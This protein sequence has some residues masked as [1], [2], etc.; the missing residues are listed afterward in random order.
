MQT[1][2]K[3]MITFHHEQQIMLPIGAQVLT[4]EMQFDQ[5]CIWYL[6]DPSKPVV[7]HTIRVVGTGIALPDDMNLFIYKGTMQIR[8]GEVVYHAF[9]KQG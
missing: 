6:C 9:I 7:A 3:Q 2:H 8:D 4:I 5:P 1:I